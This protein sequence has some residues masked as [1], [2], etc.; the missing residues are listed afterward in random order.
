MKPMNLFI[1]YLVSLCIRLVFQVMVD[2]SFGTGQQ[3]SLGFYFLIVH[4]LIIKQRP[5]SSVF[6]WQHISYSHFFFGV[7]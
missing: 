4:S 3:K 5:H 7:I 1:L 2:A 6:K